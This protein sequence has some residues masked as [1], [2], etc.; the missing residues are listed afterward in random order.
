MTEW[1]DDSAVCSAAGVQCARLPAVL[2]W[3]SR[4]ALGGDVHGPDPA[5]G[6][7]ANQDGRLRPLLQN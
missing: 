5:R 2:D 3:D 6:A 7:A 1:V 4:G